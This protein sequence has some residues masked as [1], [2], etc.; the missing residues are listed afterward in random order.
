M[1]Y[2]CDDC[3]VSIDFD[4]VD[5]HSKDHHSS[6]SNRKLITFCLFCKQS[7]VSTDNA[8]WN[9]HINSRNHRE[10]KEIILNTKNL[11]VARYLKKRRPF[12]QPTTETSEEPTTNSNLVPQEQ[13]EA[14]QTTEISSSLNPLD[15]TLSNT[16]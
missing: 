13:E 4:A 15:T 11:D 5:Q 1:K 10:N 8:K 14:M 6:K 12:A 16:E 9:S 7:F 3:Q 2:R